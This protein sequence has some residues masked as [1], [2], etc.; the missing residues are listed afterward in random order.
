LGL[1]AEGCGA[2]GFLVRRCFVGRVAPSDVGRCA[3]GGG[4][5][6]LVWCLRRPPGLMVVQGQVGWAE[7]IGRVGGSRCDVVWT[8]IGVALGVAACRGW[9]V[10]RRLV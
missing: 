10:W 2:G 6:G 8:L 3:G 4:V 7:R 1:G 9:I 5:W